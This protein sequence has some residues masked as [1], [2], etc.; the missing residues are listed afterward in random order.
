MECIVSKPGKPATW[1]KDGVKMLPSDRV[2]MG[3]DGAGKYMLTITNAELKDEAEYSIK[4]AD[5]KSKAQALVEGKDWF[6]PSL[7]TRISQEADIV[8]QHHGQ[9]TVQQ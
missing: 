6:P 5:K 1:Y 3:I 4:L 7:F 8:S 2:K 9:M